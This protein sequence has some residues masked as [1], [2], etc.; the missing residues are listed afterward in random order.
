MVLGVEGDGVL[1]P[2]EGPRGLRPR[3]LG[4]HLA[5]ELLEVADGRGSLGP[6][7]DVG[8]RP[9]LLIAP[10]ALVRLVDVVPSGWRW[11]RRKSGIG[12]R[13]C[14]TRLIAPGGL[15]RLVTPALAEVAITVAAVPAI[16]AVATS[17][18]GAAVV[19]V[20]LAA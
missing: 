11:Q 1:R 13:V 3:E 16:A 17:A 5:R 20:T 6:A 9:R 10:S 18:A 8:D 12:L 4:V 19:A 14:L 2:L 7:E 15:T